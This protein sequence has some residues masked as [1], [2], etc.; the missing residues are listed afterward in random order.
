[1]VDEVSISQVIGLLGLR[2]LKEASR[3]RGT[4][5]VAL[6][7]DIAEEKEVGERSVVC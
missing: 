6:E 5:A 3:R 4:P 2:A 1:M 7:V